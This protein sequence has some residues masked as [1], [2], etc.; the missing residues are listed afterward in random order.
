[1]V[2]LVKHHKDPAAVALGRKG[3]KARIARLSDEGRSH[4]A[5]LAVQTRW[6]RARASKNTLPGNGEWMNRA[7]S[8][9]LMS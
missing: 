9:E 1:M 8:L 7:L 3:G 4:L 5:R 6:A 2:K